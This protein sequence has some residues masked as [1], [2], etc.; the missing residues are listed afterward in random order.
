MF[1]DKSNHASSQECPG[2]GARVAVVCECGHSFKIKPPVY[3]TRRSK[4]IAIA[5]QQ[6]RATESADEIALRLVKDS[7]R[8]AQKRALETSDETSSRQEQ[9][10]ACK[11]KRKETETVIETAQRRQ[12][13]RACKAKR[14]E[15]ETVV[16]YRN[17]T[18]TRAGSSM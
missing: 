2:C 16:Y 1:V 3:S 17:C 4:R 15:S 6:Q 18:T 9:D 14:R 10:R 8:K 12:Q 7:T 11:A 13:D 5:T